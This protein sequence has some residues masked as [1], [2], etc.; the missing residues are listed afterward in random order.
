MPVKCG[1]HVP[2]A[3][4]SSAARAAGGQELVMRRRNLRFNIA[5]LTSLWLIAGSARADDRKA[6][7]DK[8][9]RLVAKLGHSAGVLSAAFSPEGKQVLTGTSDG[10]ALS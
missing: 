4:W 8:R 2:D 7:P 6:E 3:H 1:L 9:P 5:G 10:T